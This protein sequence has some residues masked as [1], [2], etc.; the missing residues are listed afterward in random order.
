MNSGASTAAYTA[1]ACSFVWFNRK[2]THNEKLSC[3][4]PSVQTGMHFNKR[5]DFISHR[6][7]TAGRGWNRKDWRQARGSPGPGSFPEIGSH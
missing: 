4:V 5:L 1:A 3:Q 2:R 7:Q 6:S